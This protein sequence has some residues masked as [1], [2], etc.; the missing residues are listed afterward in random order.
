MINKGEQIMNNVITLENVKSYS[1]EANLHKALAKYGLNDYRDAEDHAPMRY[2]V[3]K[4]PDD[5]WTATFLVSEYFRRN[6]TGGYVGVASQYGF[7]SL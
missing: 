2:I 5:R 1:T 7:M 3:C 4:T 6:N